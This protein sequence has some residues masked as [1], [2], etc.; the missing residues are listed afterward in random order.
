MDTTEHTLNICILADINHE[1]PKHSTDLQHYFQPLRNNNLTGLFRK[2]LSSCDNSLSVPNRDKCLSGLMQTSKSSEFCQSV[3]KLICP[4]QYREWEGKISQPFPSF[5]F[6]I[7]IIISITITIIITIT[8][9]LKSMPC[10]F[11]SSAVEC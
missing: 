11:K 5:C 9:L 4:R 10:A 6:I 2:S 8:N 3:T 7:F 1:V